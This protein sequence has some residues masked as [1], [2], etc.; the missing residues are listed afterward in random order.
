M[1]D[2]DSTSKKLT[3]KV[4][5]LPNS[6]LKSTAESMAL[7]AETSILTNQALEQ[8]VKNTTNL[9]KETE[10]AKKESFKLARGFSKLYKT[11]DENPASK[12]MKDFGDQWQ[13]IRRFSSRFLPG[14]WSFQNALV[15]LMKQ[16]EVILNWWDRKGTRGTKM[17]GGIK[18]G[19]NRLTGGMKNIY[20]E[21]LIVSDELKRGK[22]SSDELKG[23]RFGKGNWLRRALRK[24]IGPDDYTDLDDSAMMQRYGGK[25]KLFS[26]KRAKD[27][28]Q[29]LRDK[30]TL[31]KSKSIIKFKKYRERLSKVR[32]DVF[33]KTFMRVAGIVLKFVVAFFAAIF[34]LKA[35]KIDEVLKGI[36][37]TVVLMVKAV[38]FGV[39]KIIEGGGNILGGIMDLYYSFNDILSEGN[40]KPF[41]DALWR[42]GKGVLQVV[43]GII[44]TVLGPII[45]G[46]WGL[47]KHTLFDWVTSFWGDAETWWQ[48]TL[49][50]IQVG[51]TAML[52]IAAFWAAPTYIVGIIAAAVVTAI[53]FALG[54]LIPGRS[55]GGPASGLT[56]VGEKGP[57]L[58]N[59]PSGSNVYSN[60]ESK[61]IS[62]GTTNNI[63]VNVQG[64][65]GASDSELREI[66]QKVGRM[67]NL[68]LNRTTSTRTRGA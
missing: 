48:K 54:R 4:T 36:W 64:R 50:L 55:M 16:T 52:A 17:F 34:I 63:T 68:E 39:T 56:L 13:V 43:G 29:R 42:I 62:A 38:I 18:K 27:R 6:S 37:D 67:I 51:V 5:K 61:R 58:V 12:F 24:K 66:A 14:F 26:T 65:V 1:V 33:F 31:W 22:T 32:W 15:G 23:G 57:E 49:I 41:L 21:E 45:D 60:S 20:E 25:E 46:I 44:W 28:F 53:G 7:I 9:K 30:I 59:L 47:L 11:S 19:F 3:G 35:F 2:L 40:W 8:I 10:K